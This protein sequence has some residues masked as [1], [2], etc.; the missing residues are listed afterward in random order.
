VQFRNLLFRKGTLRTSTFSVGVDPKTSTIG[1]MSGKHF[2]LVPPLVVM[3]WQWSKNPPG[4][5]AARDADCPLSQY[6]MI[7]RM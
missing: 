7:S 3:R 1:T 4:S 6:S 2:E 5:K